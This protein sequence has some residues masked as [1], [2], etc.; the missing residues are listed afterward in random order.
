MT[1]QG[2]D[3]DGEQAEVV[4][5]SRDFAELTGRYRGEL[6]V[7]CY[8]MLGSVQDAEDLVQET[9]LRAWR[10]RETYQGRATLRAWL[11]KIA[12]N[13]C[14]DQLDRRV[15]VPLPVATAAPA[16]P[17]AAPLPAVAAA[18]LRPCPDGLLDEHVVARE[19]VELA[20]LAAVQHLP[21]RQRAVLALR[22]VL[23]WPAAEVADLLGSTVA[24]VNSA[25]Q[26]A[27]STMRTQLPSRRLDWSA[28]TST[29]EEQ[30]VVRRYMAALEHGDDAE[31]ATLLREDARCSQAPW[32]GGNMSDDPAWYEGR[33]TL[34]EAWRPVFHGPHRQEFRCVATAANGDPAVATYVR[35]P[36][37]G[38]FRPF[39][40]SVLRVVDGRIAEITVFGA[41]LYPL[42]GLPAER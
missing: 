6:Q 9:F 35:A 3:M 24:S 16:D 10:R 39:G 25:L 12:T 18:W 1:D 5:T 31:L 37:G 13:A 19:T 17:T 27:R 2:G 22:D 33:D 15:P 14:L 29:G 34:V 21:A 26:R 40:L 11:Y 8:R 30:A 38:P 42:F 7:H 28:R 36:G 41:G 20:F 4:T 23:G 32:A